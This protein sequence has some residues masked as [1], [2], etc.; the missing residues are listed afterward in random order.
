MSGPK[1]ESVLIK[2]INDETYWF[3]RS[4][5]G[6]TINNAFVNTSDFYWVCNGNNKNCTFDIFV[7]KTDKEDCPMGGQPYVTETVRIRRNYGGA[8]VDWNNTHKHLAF[9]QSSGNFKM[10][11]DQWKS[12]FKLSKDGYYVYNSKQSNDNNCYY[13][14]IGSDDLNEATKFKLVKS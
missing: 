3:S 5:Q 8:W 10:E 11:W 12:S 14:K 6:N 13:V 9:Y 1:Y 4:E 7:D 2:D